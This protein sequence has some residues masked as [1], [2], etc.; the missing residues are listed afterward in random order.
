MEYF[1][2]LYLA[3]RLDAIQH[4]FHGMVAVSLASLA[5]MVFV[6]FL[7]TIDDGG[8]AEKWKLSRAYRYMAIVCLFIG[9]IGGALTPDKKDAMFIAGGVGVIEATKAVAGSKIAQTSVK[10][11]EEWLDKELADIKVKTDA[12]KADKKS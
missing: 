11:V 7:W 6:T 9:L 1:W 12:K 4:A 10:I 2:W 5:L 3:T 8:F